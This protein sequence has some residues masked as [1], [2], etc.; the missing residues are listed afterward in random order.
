M[1]AEG[2]KSILS[3]SELKTEIKCVDSIKKAYKLIFEDKTVNHFDLISL[4]ISMPPFIERNLKNGIDLAEI[5]RKNY[6]KI[7]IIILTGGCN[8]D[9]I[10]V[11]IRK[12]NP[13]GF[14]QKSDLNAENIDFIFNQIIK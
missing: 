8:D 14:I 6:P 12:I 7:K 3:Y 1:L 2:I 9:D 10:S 4:D 11:I 13:N 5:I